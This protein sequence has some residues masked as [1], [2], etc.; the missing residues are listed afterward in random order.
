MDSLIEL[1]TWY[2]YL[3][4]YNQENQ[5]MLSST[6]EAFYNTE[7]LTFQPYDVSFYGADTI[8]ISF[9]PYYKETLLV[10]RSRIDLQAVFD[11]GKIIALGSGDS[12]F[13][14]D[15]NPGFC[16]NLSTNYNSLR[17]NLTS[18]SHNLNLSQ[19]LLDNCKSVSFIRESSACI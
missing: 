12:F 4:G 6:N 13:Y 10:A 19:W 14:F 7:A 17:N 1:G 15:E 5:M 9:E 18:T 2:L 3:S 11:N 16:A 8:V